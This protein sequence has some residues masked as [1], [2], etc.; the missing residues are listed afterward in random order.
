MLTAA[1]RLLSKMKSTP[2]QVDSPAVGVSEVEDMEVDT[3]AFIP[4]Q[5]LSDI[6]LEFTWRYSEP[7]SGVLKQAQGYH[8]YEFPVCAPNLALLGDIGLVADGENGFFAWL[9]HQLERFERVFF[10]LGNHEFYKLTYV[11]TL[12]LSTSRSFSLDLY[13][14]TQKR[15]LMLSPRMLRKRARLAAVSSASSSCSTRLATT[16]RPP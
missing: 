12:N 16:C 7:G 1:R 8:V 11:C 2:M 10:L 13:R 6:H 14:T 9:R 3:T 15:R 5:V 4:V